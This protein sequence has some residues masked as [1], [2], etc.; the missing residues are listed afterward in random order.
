MYDM[1]LAGD[2]MN[3]DAVCML[4]WTAKDYNVVIPPDSPHN[5]AWL[6]LAHHHFTFQVSGCQEARIALTDIPFNASVNAYEIVLGS[7]NNMVTQ[8]YRDAGSG[9]VVNEANTPQILDC[10]MYRPF[11]VRYHQHS[12]VIQVGRG[13]LDADVLL[14]W[15]DENPR[16]VHAVS[17][18]SGPSEEVR[19]QFGEESG[20]TLTPKNQQ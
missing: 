6:V 3:A 14:E 12:G 5:K 20:N 13:V 15:T 10:N 16:N 7:D 1:I 2:D 4:C 17:F 9:Q 11:W 18:G 19:Y 8:I